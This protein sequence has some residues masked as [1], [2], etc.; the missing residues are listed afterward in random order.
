MLQGGPGK[1]R[2]RTSIFTNKINKDQGRTTLVILS[3]LVHLTLGVSVQKGAHKDV[4]FLDLCHPVMHTYMYVNSE[5][6]VD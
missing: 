3:S 6:A 1:K 2:G 5:H 4:I